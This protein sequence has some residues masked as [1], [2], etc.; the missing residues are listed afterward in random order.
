MSQVGG[1]HGR[2]V[3]CVAQWTF[4]TCW[5]SKCSVCNATF[6]FSSVAGYLNRSV[7]TWS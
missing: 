5:K 6:P 1:A 4:C 2:Q 7:M 3:D